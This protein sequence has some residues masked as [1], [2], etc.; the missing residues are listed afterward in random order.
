MCRGQAV[1]LLRSLF[2]L[3]TPQ[4]A[5]RHVLKLLQQQVLLLLLQMLRLLLLSPRPNVAKVLHSRPVPAIK[6]ESHPYP[7]SCICIFA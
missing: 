6:T 1:Q 2:N 4:P 3:Y 7:G 5:A